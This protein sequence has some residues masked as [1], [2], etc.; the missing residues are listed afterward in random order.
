[1]PAQQIGAGE[2]AEE[3]RLLLERQRHRD[4]RGRGADIAED[5]EDASLEQ[6]LRHVGDRA[7]RLV[8]VVEGDELQ[9]AAVDPAQVVDLAKTESDVDTRRSLERLPDAIGDSIITPFE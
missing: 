3:Q 9:P 7:A 6:Q 2:G 5:R 4:F 1:M 8:A